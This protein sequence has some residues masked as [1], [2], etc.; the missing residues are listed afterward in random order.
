M[1]IAKDIATEKAS[2]TPHSATEKVRRILHSAADKANGTLHSATEKT[3]SA[4]QSTSVQRYIVGPDVYTK[5]CFVSDRPWPLAASSLRCRSLDSFFMLPRFS[6]FSDFE[7]HPLT[8]RLA[9]LRSAWVGLV[10]I[11][12]TLVISPAFGYTRVHAFSSRAENEKRRGSGSASAPV[13]D[14]RPMSSTIATGPFEAYRKQP[15]KTGTGGGCRHPR[16]GANAAVEAVSEA[17]AAT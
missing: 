16:H 3:Q 4:K 7:V 13:S 10:S 6:L 12:A 9:L 5:E 1:S 14:E 8:P 11:L 15:S 2:G 17:L